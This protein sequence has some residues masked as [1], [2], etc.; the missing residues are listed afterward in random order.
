[1]KQY[2]VGWFLI[3]VSI[4]FLVVGAWYVNGAESAI[5]E[6]H[7]LKGG[8]CVHE[9][10][11]VCPFAA[12]YDLA[13]PK[14]LALILDAILFMFGVFLVFSKERKM[15]KVQVKLEGEEKKAYDLITKEGMIF[16]SELA[17]QL[18]LSKVKVTRILD[19]L[20]GKGLIE[21]RR[22]G[23]TNAVVAK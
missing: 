14:Y 1:M 4:G 13:T 9:E 17:E 11:Q 5:M 21:R 20:E 6:G 18:Q 23:M 10:G 3:V 2:I 8:V 16:Q 22:R 19:K 7:V 15:I 12:L